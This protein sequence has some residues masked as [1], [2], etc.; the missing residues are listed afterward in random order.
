MR[1][2]TLLA[3]LAL[4]APLTGCLDDLGGFGDG[5][6]GDEP[7]PKPWTTTFEDVVA[8][9]HRK[10]YPFPVSEGALEARV[11]V[12]LET[13]FPVPAPV[14]PAQVEIALV[15]PDGGPAGERR[16]LGPQTPSG[17]IVVR[18][19]TEFGEYVVLVTGNGLSGSGEGAAYNG[20]ITVL[21]PQ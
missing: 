19:F 20:T 17:T 14:T 4:V 5:M 15:G 16:I 13:R 7:R 9:Q 1:P 6:R 18:E 8:P 2:L 12:A 3:A 10:E 11:D 21:Y